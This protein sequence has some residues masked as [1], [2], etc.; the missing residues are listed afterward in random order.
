MRWPPALSVHDRFF[1]ITMQEVVLV[2]VV[3]VYY[4]AVAYLKMKIWLGPKSVD[5]LQGVRA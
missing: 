5:V 4:K 3:S 2:Y 1:N